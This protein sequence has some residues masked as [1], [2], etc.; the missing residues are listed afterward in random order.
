MPTRTPPI[1]MV[2]EERGKI[3]LDQI[4][5]DNENPACR[6]DKRPANPMRRT[7]D[8]I[9]DDQCPECSGIMVNGRCATCL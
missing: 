5:Q 8:Q 6:D 7:P 2:R 4:D 1:E 3:I 9:I